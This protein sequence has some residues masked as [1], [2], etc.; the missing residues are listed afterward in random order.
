M[1]S[2]RVFCL[3]LAIAVAL[4]YY[5]LEQDLIPK[6]YRSE[7][8]AEA[9]KSQVRGKRVLLARADRGRDL[10][11][12]ELAKIAEVTQVAVYSQADVLQPGSESLAGLSRGEID[13]VLLTSSNIARA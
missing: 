7:G 11:R 13:Y 1:G 5:Y 12:D 6:E 4:R 10:L 9:L 8:L 3:G 2:G